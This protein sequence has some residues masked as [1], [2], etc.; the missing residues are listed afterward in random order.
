[1]VYWNT[2]FAGFV[3]ESESNLL[4]RAGTQINGPYF[5]YWE[6]R[7]SLSP[8]KYFRLRSPGEFVLS[9]PSA[10]AIQL[11]TNNAVLS[12][13]AL[14]NGFTLQS[15]TDLAPAVPWNDLAGPYLVNA[16]S[17][18]YREPVAAAQRRFYR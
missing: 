17:Y 18:E 16:G 7:N 4:A 6:A 10:L 1:M 15:K 12:W 14:L 9:L 11:Q 2:N 5:E 8:Q 3:L 13:P